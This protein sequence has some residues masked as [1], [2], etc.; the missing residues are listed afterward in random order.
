MALMYREKTVWRL[1]AIETGV[2][3][4]RYN[5]AMRWR[6]DA[7][8]I[9]AGSLQVSYKPNGQYFVVPVTPSSEAY[10]NIVIGRQEIRQ[11]S[12]GA[13]IYDIHEMYSFQGTVDASEGYY[14]SLICMPS[15]MIA[16]CLELSQYFLVIDN[17]SKRTDVYFVVEYQID[18]PLQVT[19]I[20]VDTTTTDGVIT[21]AWKTQSQTAFAM[22]I[23]DSA[24]AIVYDVEQEEAEDMQHVLAARLLGTGNYK[25]RVKTATFV[26]TQRDVAFAHFSDMDGY[27]PGTISEWAERDIYLARKH[28]EIVS[29]EPDG[30]AQRR[31]QDIRAYWTSNN[32]H[33]YSLLVK[34]NGNVLRTYA[35]RTDTAITIPANTLA[36]GLTELELTLSYV[37][38]WGTEADTV[39]TTK[40]ITFDA[41]GTPP[42]PVLTIA[43]TVNTAFPTV[44]WTA[45]DQ[46]NFRL[47]V[48]SGGTEIQDTGEVP[49]EQRQYQLIDPLPNG[50]YL[51]RLTV[52]NE[53]GLYSPTAEKTITVSYVL[54]QKPVI[55]CAGDTRAGAINVR[56][57]NAA[58]GNF[59]HCD[60][61][62]RAAGGDW[63]R[64]LA[65]QPK[66]FTW[67][68]Y[69]VA[70]GEKY[71]YRARAISNTSGYQDGD[72]GSASVDVT[73][74]ELFE[75]DA[76]AER[77]ILRLEPERTE[78]PR[79]GV[80]L[81]E[82]A[83]ANA[84]SV[85]YGEDRYSTVSASFYATRKDAEQLKKLYFDAATL[86]YRDNRGRLF[87][88]C[89]SGEPQIKDDAYG[90]CKVSFLFT[91]T[92]HAEGV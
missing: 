38:D 85:E 47:Q 18:T 20:T 19:D 3:N 39:Y 54:P 58:Q 34:Q 78:T 57:F 82:Y 10:A 69:A 40:T 70:S 11:S 79:R 60:L 12:S 91:E 8:K 64:V 67:D 31:E 49:S 4:V 59:D 41:Y 68:D 42:A 2:S 89:L 81:M 17:V 24:G 53:Y 74:T 45:E 66:S 80:Y 13:T 76:P 84:P 77:I 92:R 75:P 32:Q 26:T 73:G 29:F 25:I 37:P 6:C 56:V 88:G 9:S 87:Y 55:Y 33:G 48:L 63:V 71:E 52:R 35:G 90:W 44:T 51:L 7:Y 14:T 86:I 62:R 23:L 46:Y 21:V 50:T 27:Y 83:G 43:G 61:F 65:G 15:D 22:Q 16:E 72:A 28:A 36:R 30:V 5:H 1:K